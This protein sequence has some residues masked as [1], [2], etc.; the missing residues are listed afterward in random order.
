MHYYTPAIASVSRELN[1]AS[2]TMHYIVS[3]LEGTEIKLKHLKPEHN[4][5]KAL[6]KSVVI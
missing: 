6:F 4:R 1:K 2:F 5:L 3:L